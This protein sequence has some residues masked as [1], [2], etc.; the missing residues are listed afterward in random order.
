MAGAPHPAWLLR[1]DAAA[2]QVFCGN[3]E[4]DMPLKELEVLFHKYGEVARVDMKQ[5]AHRWTVVT[6]PREAG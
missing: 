6:R 2:V 1:T 5:G 3:F 4:Y